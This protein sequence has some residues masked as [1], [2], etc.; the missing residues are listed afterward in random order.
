MSTHHSGTTLQ[1]PPVTAWWVES[2]L[3][4]GMEEALGLT[5]YWNA[6]DAWTRVMADTVLP[7]FRA[8]HAVPWSP[9]YLYEVMLAMMLGPR[10]GGEPPK[11]AAKKG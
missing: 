4:R 2:C 6:F 9:L 3:G 5:A 8:A 10:A 11:E 7:T 1:I